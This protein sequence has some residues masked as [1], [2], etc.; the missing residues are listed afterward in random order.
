MRK[1]SKLDISEKKRKYLLRGSPKNE[2]Q[3]SKVQAETEDNV[4]KET[5]AISS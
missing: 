4:G 5:S 3:I 2:L 1:E